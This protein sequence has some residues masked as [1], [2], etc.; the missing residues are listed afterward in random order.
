[1]D[2]KRRNDGQVANSIGHMFF[3]YFAASATM[4]SLAFSIAV[5]AIRRAEY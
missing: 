2:V 1:M 4:F 5:M 3:A